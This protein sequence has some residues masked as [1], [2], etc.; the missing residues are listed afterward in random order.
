MTMHDS[1]VRAMALNIQKE[2]RSTDDDKIMA[3]KEVNGG[4]EVQEKQPYIFLDHEQEEYQY[5]EQKQQEKQFLEHE[6]KQHQEQEADKIQQEVKQYK[7]VEKL[8]MANNVR[9]KAE[10]I[11]VIKEATKAMKD[12][13]EDSLNAAGLFQD[14]IRKI[15]KEREIATCFGFDDE[16]DSE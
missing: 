13:P 1:N 2:H 7:I 15:R 9:N 4:R 14:E 5:M 12:V 3:T 11:A 16:S 8:G 6:N 10:Y